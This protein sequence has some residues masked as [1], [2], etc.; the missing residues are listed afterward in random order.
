[1]SECMGFIHFSA[2]TS[3]VHF[4]FSKYNNQYLILWAK[5]VRQNELHVDG[6][7]DSLGRSCAK[8]IPADV[9]VCGI[10]A[11]FGITPTSSSRSISLSAH[12]VVI[13]GSSP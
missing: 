7:R 3:T 11:N 12:C 4:S 5:A 6:Y 1:M 2:H 8:G 9:C 10:G 13:G